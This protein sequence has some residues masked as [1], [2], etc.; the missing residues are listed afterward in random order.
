MDILFISPS[1]E[2]SL[3]SILLGNLDEIT[4]YKKVATLENW[5]DENNAIDLYIFDVELGIKNI[6]QQIHLY[7]QQN[8]HMKW[9]VINL[10]DIYQSLQYIKAGASGILTSPCNEKKLQCS[11]HSIN[12]DQLYLE[13]DLVQI[14]A[15]RQIKKILSP[16]NQL[17]SREFDVFCLLAENYAIQS[18]AEMLTISSKTAFNCQTQLRKKLGL[19]DLTQ[20]IQFAQKNGLI[21]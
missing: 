10:F 5:T 19:K 12:N 1:K 14:L 7:R 4:T 20:V 17:T 3:C 6:F 8:S 18:I 16:F 11:L 9:L 15:L 13:E 21:L 2:N